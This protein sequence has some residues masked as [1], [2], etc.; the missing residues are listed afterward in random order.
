MECLDSA[1]ARAVWVK[2]KTFFP[3]FAEEVEKS[4]AA[5]ENEF[6]LSLVRGAGYNHQRLGQCSLPFHGP[7]WF[8]GN[9]FQ[10]WILFIARPPGPKQLVGSF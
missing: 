5:V 9:K 4:Q 10:K 7:I 8:F 3:N 1:V 2:S 6:G